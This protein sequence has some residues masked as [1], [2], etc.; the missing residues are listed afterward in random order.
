M[1]ISS[2]LSQSRPSVLFPQKRAA[3]TIHELILSLMTLFKTIRIDVTS[4]RPNKS[5]LSRD[6]PRDRPTHTRS[7]EI[8][9]RTYAFSQSQSLAHASCF[10]PVCP[11]I[12]AA[13]CDATPLT[14]RPSGR[15]KSALTF[16]SIRRI[17][18]HVVF[19]PGHTHTTRPL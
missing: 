3:S 18:R 17:I 15:K 14:Q 2:N 16:V 6:L 9:R 7:F 19:L 10:Y 1:T 5:V 13:L 4:M 8:D 12:A 11:V